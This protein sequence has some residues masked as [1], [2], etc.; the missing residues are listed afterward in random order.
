MHVMQGASGLEADILDKFEILVDET[1][2]PVDF[3][4]VLADFLL[5]IVEKR[6]SGRTSKQA[7]VGVKTIGQE[8]DR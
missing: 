5:G 1:A 7:Q 8:A 2:E 4:E 6:R 3:D